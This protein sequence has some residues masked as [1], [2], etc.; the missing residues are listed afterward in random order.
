MVKDD[1]SGPIFLTK[2]IKRERERER[3]KPSVVGILMRKG[4][5]LHVGIRDHAPEEVTFEVVLRDE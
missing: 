5:I 2:K 3:Y 4:S 1:S